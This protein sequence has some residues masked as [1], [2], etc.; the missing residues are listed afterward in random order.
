ML[1]GQFQQHLLSCL[2]LLALGELG[3]LDD[4][5]FLKKNLPQLLGRTDVEPHPR[6]VVN[7]LF[8]ITEFR[9]HRLRILLQRRHVHLDTHTL[10]LGQYW[11]QRHLHTLKQ[12]D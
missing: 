8:N 5:Q 10:H 1:V 4:A 7:L 3:V 9:V 2:V 11:H 12:C 6:I